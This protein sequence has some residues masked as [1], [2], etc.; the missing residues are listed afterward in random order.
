MSSGMMT[1]ANAVTFSAA[2][3]RICLSVNAVHLFL[4]GNVLSIAA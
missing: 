3:R 1:K 2:S 4:H